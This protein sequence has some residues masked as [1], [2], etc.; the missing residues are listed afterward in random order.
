M[1]R[2]QMAHPIS[3]RD[4]FSAGGSQIPIVTRNSTQSTAGVQQMGYSVG[5][6]TLG[7]YRMGDSDGNAPGSAIY[8]ND[9]FSPLPARERKQP[10]VMF[11]SVGFRTFQPPADDDKLHALLK[12][13]GDQQFK[14]TESAPFEE[15]F[16]INELAR[17]TDEAARM[18]SVEDQGVTREIMRSLVDARRQ[19]SE[20][21]FSRRMVD[22]G[23]SPEAAQMEIDNVNRASAIQ[24]A[25]TVDDRP[26]QQKLLISRIA[27]A[28]GLASQVKGPLSQSAGISV[29]QN[30][31]DG[32]LAMGVANTGF[33]VGVD[34]Q[35]VTPEFYSRFGRRAPDTQEAQDQQAAVNYLISRGAAGEVTSATQLEGLDRA[36]AI[37]KS[38]EGAASKLETL[39]NRGNKIMLPLP[40]ISFFSEPLLRQVYG[41]RKPGEETYFTTED[42][43]SLTVTQSIIA[44]NQLLSNPAK[45]RE[46]SQLLRASSVPILKPDQTA[47]PNVFEILRRLVAALSPGTIQL[48]FVGKTIDLSV[49]SGNYDTLANALDRVRSAG[50]GAPVPEPEGN[51]E[52]VSDAA[53]RSRPPRSAPAPLWVSWAVGFGVPLPHSKTSL[54][55]RF[56]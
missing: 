19:S 50:A 54:V 41:G 42:S 22:A 3:T 46:A 27:Q 15:Y 56:R 16:R 44:M 13:F 25:R 6:T 39:R 23:L 49:A 35:A 26:Y 14:A 12:K 9:I 30:S 8:P 4:Q 33:G 37:Q 24:E 51:P 1:T 2:K 29:P 21:D 5:K 38:R 32:N 28:R 47:G 18:S 31:Q 48:P 43:Q 36:E 45:V 11:Q 40:G 7:P 52:G 17:M 10:E 55:G 20:A 34:R 53:M